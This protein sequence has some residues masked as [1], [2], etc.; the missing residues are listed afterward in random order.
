MNTPEHGSVPGPRRIGRYVITRELGRGSTS[1]VYLA[2][3]SERGSDVALKLY[4]GDEVR[5]ERAHTR[6]KL[7]ANE[8]RL[9]GELVHPYIAQVFDSGETE[10][11]AY[12]VTEYLSGAEALGAY[13]RLGG[14]LPKRRVVE[15][16]FACARALDYAHGRGVVH[17]DV[18]PTNI[19]L[20]PAGVPK[21]IDFGI[22]ATS[23]TGTQTVTGLL[24][25]PSYMAPEQVRDGEA[26]ALSDV[27]SLG[28]VGYE[29]LAGR[30][31]FYG[32]NLSHLVHQIIYATPRPLSRLRA[33]VP[34]ELEAVVARAM[35][36]DPA[37]RF[38]NALAM[39][40][41]LARV[42]AKLGREAGRFDLRDRFDMA[43]H[44]P[45]F[46]D[47]GYAEVWEAV[48]C[49]EWCRYEEGE[50]VVAAGS[51]E[52]AFYVVFAGEIGLEHN[53]RRTR[54]LTRGEAFAEP[55]AGGARPMTARAVAPSLVM[56]VDSRRLEAAS[57]ACQLAF[58]KLLNRAL[59]HRLDG[60]REE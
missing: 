42:S 38:P 29:L 52:H 55:L 32:E 45:P 37:R 7:F 60:L 15:I 39:A 57:T 20:T 16:L 50:E 22:A 41:S 19:L 9:A 59:L 53:G 17:R 6:R 48:S 2:H 47:F 28:V 36:K 46:R 30:R 40:A 26:S 43:R 31:P 13:A 23:L 14:L 51:R 12:V 49:G 24:G 3:D 44:L 5:P 58:H 54:R 11:E 27:Y 33:S 4:H 10:D 8:A 34:A 25:S 21:L 35:E 1:R 18:K 56:R